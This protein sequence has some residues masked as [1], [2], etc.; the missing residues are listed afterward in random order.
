MTQLDYAFILEY[1]EG[2]IKRLKKVCM[3]A[4]QGAQKSAD[5]LKKI[6]ASFAPDALWKERK[7][8]TS[9]LM[10]HDQVLRDV[11]PTLERLEE[12]A[13]ILSEQLGVP[14]ELDDDE[15][16]EIISEGIK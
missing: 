9:A 4:Q 7:D 8:T 2:E 1:I 10:H 16:G 3:R 15:D 5:M 12:Q 6:D 11:R 14:F 13:R